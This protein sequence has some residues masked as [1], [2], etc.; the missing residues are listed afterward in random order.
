M[1]SEFTLAFNSS[2]INKEV[3]ILIEKKDDAHV[4][5]YA[6]QYFYVAAIGQGTVGDVV[7]VK[8]DKIIDDKVIGHVS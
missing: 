5:G 8:I 7:N 1:Q 2:F 4:Y 3:E 6:K